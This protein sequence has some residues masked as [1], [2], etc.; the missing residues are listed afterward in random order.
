MHVGKVFGY[1]L[2]SRM[3]PIIPKVGFQN[4]HAWSRLRDQR[5]ARTAGHGK[6]F[7]IIFAMHVWKVFASI[8]DSNMAAKNNK[9]NLNVVALVRADRWSQQGVFEVPDVISP[10]SGRTNVSISATCTILHVD[11]DTGVKPID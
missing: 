5:F 2:G 8:L 4:F 6:A 10:V 3:T 11:C 1:V 7:G 9:C